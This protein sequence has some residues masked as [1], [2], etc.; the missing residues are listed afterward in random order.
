MAPSRDK[1]DLDMATAIMVTHPVGKI[2]WDKVKL[3]T[4][5]MGYNWSSKTLS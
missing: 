5:A 2:G 1:Q 4:Q 3:V